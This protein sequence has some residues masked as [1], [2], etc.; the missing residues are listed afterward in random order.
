MTKNR[1]KRHVPLDLSSFYIGRSF[2]TAGCRV[3]DTTPAPEN[4]VQY[5][6][7]RGKKKYRS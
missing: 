4:T 5:N 6:M 1:F 2:H 7:P 3:P